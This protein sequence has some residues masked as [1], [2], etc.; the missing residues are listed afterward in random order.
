VSERCAEG[1]TSSESKI[2]ENCVQQPTSFNTTNIFVGRVLTFG[3]F[4]VMAHK[5]LAGQGLLNIEASQLHS[6]T[7]HAVGLLW[8]SDQPN[9]ASPT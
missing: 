6:D 5:P 3:F 8:T 4:F 1:A 7:P 2:I 9:A